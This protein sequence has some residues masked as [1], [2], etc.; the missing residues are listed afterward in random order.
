M[1]C[2]ALDAMGV[3]FKSVDDVG[4]LLIPF[5]AEKC[6]STDEETIRSAYLA[7]SLGIIHPDEFWDRV[8]VSADS[9]DE[10]LSRH[11]LNTG[12]TELLS[13][14]K[15]KGIPIWC[16]SNDVGRWSIKLRERLGVEKVL[17][18]SVISGDVGTRKPD[19]KIYQTLIHSSGYQGENILFVDDR[20]ANVVA[21]CEAGLD[22]VR[23]DPE[24][25]FTDVESWISRC[26]P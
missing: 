6:E 14:A 23:Y 13:L 2:L 1:S 7:A 19:E 9:E 26:R 25:G 15:S 20:D 8:D 4:E 5:I 10:F 16:L 17:A 12:I 3:I 18:G 21:A 11:G 24:H 22:A